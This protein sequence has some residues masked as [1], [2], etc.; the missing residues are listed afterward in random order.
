MV[1]YQ[2]HRDDTV[3]LAVFR[4]QHDAGTNSVYWRANGERL[5]IQ[6]QL[7]GTDPRGAK[8]PLHQLAAAGADQAEQPDDLPGTHAQIDRRF[9]AGRLQPPERQTHRPQF[10]RLIAV[11]VTE[12]APHHRLHQLGIIN[13]THIVKGAHIAAIFEHRDGVAE[14][15]NLLHAV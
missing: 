6:H 12:I 15:K 4:T 13:L 7:P 5:P 3:R 9:H 2:M 10:T 11:D 14:G 8:D 1:A